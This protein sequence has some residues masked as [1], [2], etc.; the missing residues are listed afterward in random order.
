MS[1]SIYTIFIQ[2]TVLENGG[3]ES[4]HCVFD[5]CGTYMK[6][7]NEKKIIR[8]MALFFFIY[9]WF[10]HSTT[11]KLVLSLIG[12]AADKPHN[13][14][15]NAGAIVCTSLIKVTCSSQTTNVELIRLSCVI[16]SLNRTCEVFSFY[17]T[18]GLQR[19]YVKAEFR[20]FTAARKSPKV[21]SKQRE[22]KNRNIIILSECF[23]QITEYGE[24]KVID[25]HAEKGFG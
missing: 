3:G 13:P 6:L 23:R 10:P 21:E 4:S 24:I 20:L 12:P 9:C 17:F 19:R 5:V 1:C 16:G 18:S 7:F 22:R 2:D 14:M 8:L 25:N 15:V 11:K